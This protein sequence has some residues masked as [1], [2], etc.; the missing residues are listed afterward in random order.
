MSTTGDSL[1]RRLRSSGGPVFALLRA[2]A[3]R[4][5]FTCFKARRCG[6]THGEASGVTYSLA[7]LKTLGSPLSVPMA[8]PFPLGHARDR[9]T[10]REEVQ[11]KGTLDRRR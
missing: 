2:C 10:V 6:A 4:S 7:L 1:A 5:R 11:R 9:K 8:S 3:L